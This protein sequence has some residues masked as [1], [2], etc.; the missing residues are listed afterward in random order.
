MQI[1]RTLAGYSYA[2]A[3]IVRRAMSKKDE[4][5]M[6]AERDAFLKGA[7]E[8]GIDREAA[9]AVFDEMVG[10]AKYAFNKSHATAYA[11]LTYR[12]AYLKAHYPAEFFSALLTSVLD[13]PEKVRAYIA[14][15]EKCGVRVLRPDVNESRALFAVK[16]GHIRYGLLAIRN[17][18]RTLAEAVMRE[19][20]KGGRFRSMDDFVERMS[21][22]ELNR[23]TLEYLVKSGV[24][25][26]LGT[27]RSALMAAYEAVLA[28]AQERTRNNISG[29]MDMFSVVSAASPTSFGGYTYPKMKEFSQKELLMME[30]ESSGMYF[31]GH[32][33][34]GYREHIATLTVDR[35]SDIAADFSEDAQQPHYKDRTEVH[36]AG[37][38]TSLRTKEVKG[39]NLMAF[40]R[41]DDTFGELEILVFP[42]SYQRVKEHLYEDAAVY[43]TGTL[44]EEEGELPRVLLSSLIPL[45]ENGTG[46]SSQAAGTPSGDGGRPKEARVFIKVKDMMDKRIER[47]ERTAL[48]HPGDCKVV[49]Y[50]TS[51]GKYIAMKQLG[52]DPTDDVLLRL[53]SIFS[54]ENVVYRP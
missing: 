30:K 20:Q 19:R 17:V 6:L 39:G 50:D 26:S 16:D 36:L 32:L 45:R 34:D 5:V 37:I 1:C 38:L 25:D 48:F 14:D 29:Q 28:D 11:I 8:R 2:R 51:T 40:V 49:L 24:F 12:T 47:L 10:F 13:Q 42:K 15:A 21:S 3:D 54:E 22:A 18:G 46:S 33:L 44:S 35:I 4:A 9:N 23:R 27:P 7:A 43:V 52:I 31:S 53:R 41:L